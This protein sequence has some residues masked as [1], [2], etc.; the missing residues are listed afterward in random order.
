MAKE[1]AAAMQADDLITLNRSATVARL[2]SGVVHEVNNALQVIGGTTEL[3]Q[4]M[5]GL[6]DPVLKGLQRI[7]A[8]NARAAAALSE[9]MTFSRQKHDARGVVNMR[10]VM[11]RSVALRA[12]AIGRARLSIAQQAP[13]DGRISV[14]GSAMLLQQALLNLIINAEQ[15]LEGRPGG[16]ISV[17]VDFEGELVRVRVAD[18]GPGVDASVAS[19]IFEPFVTTKPRDQASGLGLTVARAIAEMH[20]GTLVCESRPPGAAFVLRIPATK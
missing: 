3:L 13:S 16:R 10:E 20:G 14:E 15:A 17:D 7:H 6:S 11:S 12:Y 5:P 18:D 1:G 19:Q 2:V 8:Q 9:V 4:D